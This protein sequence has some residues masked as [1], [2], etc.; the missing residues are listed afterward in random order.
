MA[1]R[2]VVTVEVAALMLGEDVETIRRL[3]E[4]GRLELVPAAD[5]SFDVCMESLNQ[6]DAD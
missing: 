6:L 4:E 1:E 2:P 3:A 5:G